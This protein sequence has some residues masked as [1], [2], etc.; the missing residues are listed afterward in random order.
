MTGPVFG[1]RLCERKKNTFRVHPKPTICQQKVT[2]NVLLYSSISSASVFC[3]SLA[4]EG[5]LSIKMQEVK[6]NLEENTDTDVCHRALLQSSMGPGCSLS[7]A[8]YFLTPL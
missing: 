1:S 4:I 3:E 2:M 8:V 7:G 5:A 6:C